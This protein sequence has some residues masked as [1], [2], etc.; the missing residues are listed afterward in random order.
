MAAAWSA[1]AISHLRTCTDRQRPVHGWTA[2]W[3]GL[4][5]AAGVTRA[6]SVLAGQ[7]WL[8]CAATLQVGAA[9]IALGGAA[10]G[11]FEVFVTEGNRLRSVTSALRETEDHLNAEKR[12]REEQVHDLRSAVAAL[13][14]A[15]GTLDRYD[16]R[17]D[18]GRRHDLLK[19]I[20][21]ELGRLQYLV[22]AD[23][24]KPIVEFTLAEALAP[25][26]TTEREN[27]LVIEPTLTPVRGYGR[28]ADL[29][30][31]VQQLLVN[32]RRYAPGSDVAIR[33]WRS[34]SDLC[35]LVEDRGPGV[36]VLEREAVFAR[37]ARGAGSEVTPGAGLGLY[38]A[39]RLMAEQGG[40]I[41][42]HGR[43]G[44]GARFFLTLPVAPSERLTTAA[45]AESGRR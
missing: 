24:G 14:A 28:P 7:A 37:G 5:A 22:E 23:S 43:R 32:T 38:V 12:R 1:V 33:S 17:L 21:D 36:P 25:V 15:T 3:V 13:R 9:A 44:G 34:G 29:A 39:R 30:T 19:A 10:R 16:G 18:H 41:E 35:L 40:T 31:V 8:T 2:A 42:V 20:V 27:G 26:I 45:G 11:L 4:V 6:V